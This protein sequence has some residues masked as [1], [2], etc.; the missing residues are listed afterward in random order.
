MTDT[1]GAAAAVSI[2]VDPVTQ[3][4]LS[5]SLAFTM[6]TVALGLRPQDFGFVRSHPAS[7]LVGFCAQVI[8]LPLV[9]LMLVK[10]LSLS[11]GIALGMIIVACCPGGAMSNLITKIAG[12]DSAYSVALT[13]LSS[14]FSALLLPLAILFWVSWHGPANA[15]IDEINI[16]RAEFV[17]NTTVILVIPLAIGIWTA[18]ARPELAVKLHTKFM[19]VA[20]LILIGLIV[21][22]LITNYDV[23]ISHGMQMTPIVALHNGLAFLTGGIFGRLFLKDRRKTRALVFEVGI[24][25][26]GLGLIIV[27]TQLGGL[28]EAAILVGTWSIWHLIGGFTLASIF[29]KFA[30]LSM[31]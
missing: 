23:V 20:L 15:L 8:A 6:L 12:G 25:N 4:I 22:G 11:A 18:W 24:Q 29:R 7:M 30:P 14:V 19:P 5:A 17:K 26:A 21:T 31:R 13:M 3:L 28:G 2:A 10:A 1:A 9:T 27:M 16:D